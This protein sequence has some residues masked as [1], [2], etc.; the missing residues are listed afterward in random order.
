MEKKRGRADEIAE[1]R[2]PAARRDAGAPDPKRTKRAA[3]I[4]DG[5]SGDICDDVVRNIFARLP[6]RTAVACT[7]VSTHHRRLIRSPEFRSLHLRLAPPLPRRHIAYVATAPIPRRPE[8]DPVSTFHGFHV[9]GITGNKEPPKAPMRMLA[10]GKY[11]GTSYSN[12]CNGI[13]LISGEEFSAPASCVLWNPAV[14]DDVKEVTVPSPSPEK[15]FLVLGLGYGPRSNTYKIL[16]CR[17]DTP[18]LL[19]P[20]KEQEMRKGRKVTL[21]PLLL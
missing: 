13:V 1:E 4:V 6:A 8:H 19:K 14:D 12:T 10:G 18:Q 15:E 20:V 17:K 21:N 2:D 11:L 5:A 9:A 16:L 7:A 3:T